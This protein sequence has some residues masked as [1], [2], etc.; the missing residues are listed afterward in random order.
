[1]PPVRSFGGDETGQ[2]GTKVPTARLGAIAGSAEP[3]EVA[4]L[5]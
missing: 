3:V 5:S 2:L 1:M 4:E